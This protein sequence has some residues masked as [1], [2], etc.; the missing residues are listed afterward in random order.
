MLLSPLAKNEFDTVDVEAVLA[1]T[2]L[3]PAGTNAAVVDAS[4]TTDSRAMSTRKEIFCIAIVVNVDSLFDQRF[5]C[6]LLRETARDVLS[7]IE[8]TPDASSRKD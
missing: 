5:V 8:K 1:E 7:G 3:L 4:A 6:N 2:N